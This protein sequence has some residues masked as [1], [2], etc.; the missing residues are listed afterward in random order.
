MYSY[1]YGSHRSEIGHRMVR[2]LKDRIVQH[3]R[4]EIGRDHWDDLLDAIA[5]GSSK[6]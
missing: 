2:L 1:V 3:G 6:G 4:S 5:D